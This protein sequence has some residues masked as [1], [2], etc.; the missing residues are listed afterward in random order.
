MLAAAG[1]AAPAD[2]NASLEAW[3]ELTVQIDHHVLR[4]K[5]R[6]IVIR[7][8]TNIFTLYRGSAESQ[9]AISD[10]SS[11]SAGGKVSPTTDQRSN[12]S[13]GD[14][15]NSALLAGSIAVSTHGISV[16]YLLVRHAMLAL[17]MLFVCA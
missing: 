5:S 13:R 9:L 11:W 17:L 3:S 12:T 8:E 4:P 2:T 14:P 7:C 15:D 10:E 16:R 6:K 1:D